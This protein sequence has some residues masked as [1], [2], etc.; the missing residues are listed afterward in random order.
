MPPK[1]TKRGLKRV[2]DSDSDS[3]R[4]GSDSDSDHSS[5]NNNNNSKNNKSKSKASKSKNN[6]SSSSSPFKD[7]VFVLS[8]TMSQPRKKIESLIKQNGGQISSSVT[9]KTTHLLTTASDFALNQAKVQ[10]AKSK[11]IPIVVEEFLHE[12]AKQNKLLDTTNFDLSRSSSS[13]SSKPSSSSSK[14]SKSSSKSSSSKSKSSKR[15]ISSDSG[16]DSN[17]GS[18]SDSDDNKHR[19]KRSRTSNNK[20]TNQKS[21]KANRKKKQS[22]DESQSDS[23]SKD[24]KSK[25]I[26][27][28]TD[29]TKTKVVRKGRGIVD[30]KCPNH[31]QYSVYDDG[32]S[33]YD[34]MLNQTEIGKNH[35]KFY[36]IQILQKDSDKKFFL[37]LSWGR[38][39]ER[40][41]NKLVHCRDFDAAYKEF[42]NKFYEK[43]KNLWEE[44]DTFKPVKGKYTLIELDHGDEQQSDDGSDNDSN[45]D[46]GNESKSKILT[47]KAPES[48]LDEK[49]Q[50][51]LRMIFDMKRMEQTMVE[52][53]YDINKMPLGKLTKRQI[54]EGYEVLKLIETAFKRSSRTTLEELSSR[55]YTLIPHSFGRRVPIVIGNEEILRQKMNMLE[56]LVD[57]E[58]ATRILGQSGNSTENELD[59]RY[60]K[61]ECSIAVV[62]NR[63]TEF[64]EI[65]TY[66]KNSQEPG[67]IKLELLELYK[68]ERRLEVER[69]ATVKHWGDRRLLWHGSRVTNYAG[70]FSQ[71]LRIAPP[72][73][74]CT[75]YRF[76][77]GMYFADILSLSQKYCRVTETNPIGIALLC[78]V[79]LG[80]LYKASQDEYMDKPKGDT[81]STWG[82]GVIEPDSSRNIMRN[83]YIIPAGKIVPSKFTNVSCHEHQY[84][85]YNEA[86]S[87]MR[88]ACKVKWHFSKKNK[89]N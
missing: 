8:G 55:F 73:A 82:L 36:K 31:T 24:K 1:G 65:E 50:D 12:S 52:M 39:G 13:S 42:K 15:N 46:S 43:T 10:A 29:F 83:E 5:D 9:N 16:S 69:F 19:S 48:R 88:Y 6:N 37:W 85:C 40:G 54:M 2:S 44:R 26:T 86:Q 68:I 28:A 21:I 64:K 14:S 61:L 67:S 81:H 38:V 84:I 70:I 53:E 62:D 58:I 71:G 23:D 60:E 77:K 49:V 47:I 78:E 59:S 7:I 76:G 35:N 11:G 56:A 3:D 51:L 89:S 18:G 17:S 66:F 4:S 41:R 25:S 27:T 22:S 33:V 80:K 79:A 45:S 32:N 75:G 87:K 30:P 34:A 63:T 57:I 20:N 72:E 74:P